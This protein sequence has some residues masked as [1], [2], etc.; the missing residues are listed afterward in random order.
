MYE[1][2]KRFTINNKSLIDGVLLIKDKPSGR[3]QALWYEIHGIIFIRR[4]IAYSNLFI[5]IITI[6]W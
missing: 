3:V 1:L 4:F 5:N 2:S 6:A